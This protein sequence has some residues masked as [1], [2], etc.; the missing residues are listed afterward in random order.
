[1]KK[2]IC[3]LLVLIAAI[4]QAQTTTQLGRLDVEWPDLDYPGGAALETLVHDGIAE[5]SDN[6][7]GRYTEF[8]A[9][10]DST[11]STI[12]HNLGFVVLDL[13]VQVYSGAH[14]TLTKICE[15][16][17]E[18]DTC[19]SLGWLIVAGGTPN[20]QID[21]TTPG[22]GGPHTFA[23]TITS[24]VVPASPLSLQ[25]AYDGGATASMLATDI[26]IDN[27]ATTPTSTF[28][29]ESTVGTAPFIAATTSDTTLLSLISTSPFP[30]Y[31]LIVVSTFGPATPTIA[32]PDVTGVTPSSGLFFTSGSNIGGAGGSGLVQI[33]SGIATVGPRGPVS[34]FGGNINANGDSAVNLT[35]GTG[36][37]GLTASSGVV[38]LGTTSS[39]DL[40]GN[41]IVEGADTVFTV[42]GTGNIGLGERA[43]DGFLGV[44]SVAIGTDALSSAGIV[45]A[46][47]NVAIGS[48]AMDS[49]S[50]GDARQNVAVG[51]NA[52]SA[53]TTADGT[54]AIGQNSATS[55]TTPVSN[56][57]IGQNADN[58]GTR[59]YSIALGTQA[60]LTGGGSPMMQ[61]GNALS[62]G[63][64]QIRT[65]Q[66]SPFDTTFLL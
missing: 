61:L 14:P 57:I 51:Q 1:M 35:A 40:N 34:I 66:M 38:Q 39:L 4:A 2:F 8:T 36:N 43:Q 18:I 24:G 41:D 12:T 19:L 27:D 10:A 46:S 49:A 9:I 50:L 60:V 63:S 25:A 21:V 3:F 58:T 13:G 59:N 64:G 55:L 53:I 29:L 62:T 26:V 28:T 42:A 17:S 22:S 54:V 47:E 31:P 5:F 45:T 20:T 6:I 65:L 11:T 32:T 52:L 44:T 16:N 56:T 7:S 37:V 48:S 15:F 33:Q 23:V 30:T